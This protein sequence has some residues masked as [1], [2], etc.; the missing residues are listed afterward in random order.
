MA[1]KEISSAKIRIENQ[2]I[3]LFSSK[4]KRNENLFELNSGT[5]EQIS[6]GYPLQCSG[7]NWCGMDH[8]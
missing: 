5:Y 1:R 7:L 3:E 2:R 6:N 4:E 8:S